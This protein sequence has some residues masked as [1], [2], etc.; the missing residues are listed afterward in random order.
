MRFVLGVAV[1]ALGGC[2]QSA[3][4]NYPETAHAEFATTCPT[5]DQACDCA[6]ERI[7]A[8]MSYEA[9]DAAMTRFREEGLMA[10]ELVRARE[11]CMEL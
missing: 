8:T 5:G 9:Y 1:L 6:W 10:P 3:A 4:F 11:A 7:T 2:G